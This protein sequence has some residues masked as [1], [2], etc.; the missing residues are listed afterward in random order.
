M[1][2]KELAA[3]HP[4]YCCDSNH[5]SNESCEEHENWKSFISE[6]GGE[7][8]LDMNHVFRFDLVVGEWGF[9][10]LKIYFML[11]RRGVFYPVNIKRV[12]EDEVEEITTFLK[13]HFEK[14][15]ELWKPFSDDNIF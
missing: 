13:P 9:Y 3:K 15:L 12:Q 6:W 7:L 1:T 14:T 4:Y 11:Q 10:N 8:D 5:H 2:L